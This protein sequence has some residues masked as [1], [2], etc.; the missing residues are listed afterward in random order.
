ML[1]LVLEL[2]LQLLE[3]LRDVVLVQMQTPVFHVV[4]I[5]LGLVFAALI[6]ARDRRPITVE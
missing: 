1:A 3:P 6:D 5:E 4:L 2:V